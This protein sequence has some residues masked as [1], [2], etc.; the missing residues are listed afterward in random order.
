MYRNQR[1][2]HVVLFRLPAQYGSEAILKAIFQRSKWKVHV[3]KEKQD[4]YL[5]AE[6]LSNFVDSNFDK[7][8]WIHACAWGSNSEAVYENAKDACHLR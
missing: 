4:A 7:A 1:P 3:S 2:K 8:Q 6:D 5:C